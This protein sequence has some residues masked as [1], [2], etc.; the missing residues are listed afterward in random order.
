MNY[1]WTP[2]SATLTYDLFLL[3]ANAYEGR[4]CPHSL[5]PAGS[6][7]CQCLAEF[8]PVLQQGS[9][10]CA[11]EA[12]LDLAPLRL[13]WPHQAIPSHPVLLERANR[14]LRSTSW[15]LGDPLLL[16]DLVSELPRDR[17]ARRSLTGANWSGRLGP[18]KRQLSKV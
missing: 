2:Y 7:N 16:Q 8:L 6:T 9:R 10:R 17:L 13:W 4:I 18:L 12:P 14:S 1:S 5:G 3:F 15:A 11:P